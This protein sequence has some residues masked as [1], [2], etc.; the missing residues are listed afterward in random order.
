MSN[1]V[2]DS[3]VMV[4]QLPPRYV[5]RPRLL[6][7]LDSFADRPL[8]LL[9][10]GPGAGKTV[11]LADWVRHGDAQVA[12]L[13]ATPADADSRRFWPL[14]ESALRAG[15]GAERGPPAAVP[16]AAGIDVVQA[17][18]S[19]VPESATQLV[20]IDDAHVL[21]NSDVLAD[22]DSLIRGGQPGL[23]LILAARS[24]PLLPL[25]RYR[26]AG[27]MHELRAA[28]L[29][30]T[31]GE[32][33][34]V[35]TARG[36]TLAARDFG[37]LAARTEG[38][39]AGVQLSAMRMEG[40]EYPADFVSELALDPG[41]IGEYLINEVL[42]EQPEAQRKLLI[43]T[44]FLHEVTGP[45]ADAVT[46]M[47]GCGDMLAGLARDNGFVIPLD[48]AGERYRYHELFA[49]IL[50][51]LLRRQYMRQSIR[52]LQERAIAWFEGSGDL[53]NALY[54]AVRADNRHH[55]A[56]LLARGGFVHAFVHRQ[57]LSGLGL[58]ELLP[59]RPPRGAT[60]ARTAEFAVASSVIETVFADAD[61]APGLLNRL[62]AQKSEDAPATPELLVTSDLVE[63]RLGQKAFNALAVDAAAR[64]LLGVNGD[65]PVPVVPGLPAAVLLAQASTRLWHGRHEDASMLLDEALAE[66]RRDDMPGL[67]LEVLAMMAFVSSY[68]S[69][70]N[71]ADDAAQ[72]AHA[73]RRHKNLPIP[74]ALELAAAARSLIAG[75]LDG[76]TRA[77]QQALPAVVGTDPGVAVALVLGQASA[78]LIRGEVN[79]ARTALQAVGHRIPPLL[80]VMRDMMLADT[81][82]SLGRPR[83]ALRLL[84]NYRGSEFAIL[85]AMARLR[86]HLALNDVDS[87]Q[88]CIRSVLTTPSAQVGRFIL[89]EAMLYDAQIAQLS[90]DPGRAVEVLVRAL[91]VAQGEIILPFL[92]V[93]DVF[94]E[95]L[96]RHPIVGGRW[97]VPVP[98]RPAGAAAEPAVA[99]S[100]DLPEPLTPRELTILRLLTTSMSTAEIADELCLSVNTVKTHLAAI[101][102]K[103]PAS[104]RREAVLRARQLEL[105]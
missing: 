4:P 95:L 6:R 97:P 1:A 99:A 74:P 8:T 58:R 100:R 33:A 16:R 32:I 14:L 86:A 30:M 59:L 50:R 12:W 62:S 77:I 38:W 102:R 3:R 52:G 2:R 60:A 35:L 93:N 68:W 89:V 80:A 79:E 5:S 101:Y 15:H 87:A 18:L 23:R 103:L 90:G 27:Q 57:D 98:R 17:L 44:S 13:N 26:L 47:T 67:E 69:R 84:R 46:G 104:R 72:R 55:V 70:T 91:E 31:Q 75:D 36:I 66:A 28:D 45:L 43:E 82:T 40:T 48:A 85:T 63:L 56:R 105:I 81:D 9:S 73:L 78:P 41:S 61:S 21:T 76:Q 20:I 88:D 49:E 7:V 51:Y 22:L 71:H 25:H 92:R 19:R 39:A 29:A 53:G 96:V 64:R 37:I 65:M 54:W 83:A 24:D 11:L 10:A 94:A 42:R 34:D